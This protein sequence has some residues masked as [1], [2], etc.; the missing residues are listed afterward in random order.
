MA[1]HPAFGPIKASD[2]GARGKVRVVSMVAVISC[3]CPCGSP[4]PLTL[5]VIA[6]QYGA[7]QCTACEAVIRAES[8]TYHEPRLPEPVDGKIDPARIKPPQLSIGFDI[9]RPRIVRAPAG[10]VI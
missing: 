9:Q 4:N 1:V 10:L 5:P 7:A 3:M 2:N 8:I 6:G